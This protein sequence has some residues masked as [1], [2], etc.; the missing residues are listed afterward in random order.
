MSPAQNE[1]AWYGYQVS[2]RV[3]EVAIC[4]L[5]A[6][7]A[8]TPLRSDPTDF[9][10]PAAAMAGAGDVHTAGSRMHYPLQNGI[11][12]ATAAAADSL[13]YESSSCGCASCCGG[14][15]AS[16]RKFSCQNQYHVAGGGLPQQTAKRRGRKQSKNYGHE[17]KS[18]GGL[19]C[20]WGVCGDANPPREFED[21]NYSEMCSNNR[22]VRQVLQAP[23][24][25]VNNHHHQYSTLIRPPLGSNNS[26]SAGG[27][28]Q[29]GT[30]LTALNA[31]SSSG[32]A[33]AMAV[34]SSSTLMV[35]YNHKRGASATYSQPSFQSATLLRSNFHDVMPASALVTQQQQSGSRNSGASSGNNHLTAAAAAS[36]LTGTSGSSSRATIDTA[37]YSN[38]R[39]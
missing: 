27:G 5:L 11:P 3:L 20:C 13:D 23:P 15:T 32:A 26:S 29:S 17:P 21:E 24:S 25:S 9:Y 33:A 2:M 12:S 14:T 18:R 7:I 31:G 1:W 38:L 35:P 39:G 30:E 10:G 28:G 22:S 4:T 19:M 36:V 6:I 16:R 34:G 8:T 37:L